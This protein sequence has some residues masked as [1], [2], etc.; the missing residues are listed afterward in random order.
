MKLM[1]YVMNNVN[2]LDPFLHQLKAAGIKGATILD[3]TGM[4]RKLAEN[5]DLGFD[6]F[7][8]LRAFLDNP[9]AASKLILM[10]LED[11]QVDIVSAIIDNVAGDLTKPNT[12][13][14][15]TVP[16]DFIKGYKK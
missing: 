10:A 13:I 15:F 3:S 11:N 4:G 6:L 1:I 8:S 14:F 16:I 5:D 9:R 12:G 7:G 2:Q